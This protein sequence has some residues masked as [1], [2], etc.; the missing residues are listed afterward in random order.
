ME[1]RLLK[2]GESSGRNDDNIETIRKRFMTYSNES[3]PVIEAYRDQGKLIKVD[4]N[5]TIEEVWMHV[6]SVF[7][8]FSLPTK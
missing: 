8:K 2:R 6:K 7:D 3:M 4:G 1:K 5:G